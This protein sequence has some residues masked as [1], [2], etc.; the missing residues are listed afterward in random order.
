M[1][2]KNKKNKCNMFKLCIC[3]KI[4]YFLHPRPKKEL[5]IK[6]IYTYMRTL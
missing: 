5:K 3:E 2:K 6:A 1:F 4:F